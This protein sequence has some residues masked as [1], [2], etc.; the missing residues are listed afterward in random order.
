MNYE[1]LKYL[2]SLPLE[3]K[4]SY[5]SIRIQ[6]FYRGKM[7]HKDYKKCYVSFSGGK[8]S[9][10]LLHLVRSIYPDIPAVFV[11]TGLEFPEIRD[12][13]KS[14]EN[15]VWLKPKKPFTQVIK[16]IGYP[17]VSKEVSRYVK[18]LQNPTNKNGRTR[19]IRLEGS[20]FKGGKS[21]TGKLSKK[22]QFLKDAPFKCSDRCCDI[23][24][25]SPVKKYEKITGNR[26]YI[27]TMAGESS[28]RKQ[29][30]LKSGCNVFKEGRQQSRPLSIW[31]EENIWQYIKMN[32]I[33]YSPIYDMGY[34][35]T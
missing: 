13:V 28:L 31:A 14:V 6:Q 18:D 21:T 35:R 32:S 17:V 15:V 23:M 19:R 11:D 33:D 9:T 2:Q 16:E 1:R 22:W 30:Y 12:F 3:Q 7:K 4:I 26:P 24:K 10:V 34:E 29:S 5:S 25:K 20:D 27:G 8:D